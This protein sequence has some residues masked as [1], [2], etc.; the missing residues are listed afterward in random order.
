MIETLL[1]NWQVSSRKKLVED[2][3][4]LRLSIECVKLPNGKE[5]E[6]FYQVILPEYTII[7]TVTVEGLIVLEHQYKHAVGKVI[8]N[9]PSGYLEPDETPLI[10]A[11]RELLEETGFEASKWDILGAFCV[12]GNRGCGK[13]HVFV[14]SEAR[15]V[16]EP[17]KDETEE[18]EL[19][20]MEPAEALKALLGNELATLGPVSALALAFLSPLSPFNLVQTNR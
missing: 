6:N 20:F 8:L 11:Q 10:G 4:W 5:I 3:P 15:R 12:D 1:Q 7:V 18:L 14:A 16:C 17:K 9:L 2:L 19:V 13:V